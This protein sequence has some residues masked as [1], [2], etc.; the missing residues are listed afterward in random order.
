MEPVSASAGRIFAPSWTRQRHGRRNDE[1]TRERACTNEPAL[2]AVWFCFVRK[3]ICLCVIC[4]VSASVAFLSTTMPVRLRFFFPLAR[5]AHTLLAPV[6]R[7]FFFLLSCCSCSCPDSQCAYGSC[8]GQLQR[9]SSCSRP[10]GCCFRGRHREGT[11]DALTNGCHGWLGRDRKHNWARSFQH[12]VRWRRSG[13]RP[14]AGTA[15][16]AT[17]VQCE[18]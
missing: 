10:S 6:S 5:R 16:P 8:P 15:C 17:A 12:V 1:P 18:L 4:K 7:S 9:P 3:L 13:R 11:W 2:A 14:R